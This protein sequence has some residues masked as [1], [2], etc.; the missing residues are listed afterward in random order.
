MKGAILDTLGMTKF[1]SFQSGQ[2]SPV[3]KGT[4]FCQSQV[5]RLFCTKQGF[6]GCGMISSSYIDFVSQKDNGKI[7]L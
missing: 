6:P 7:K 3:N 2:W 5:I 1:L 4:T